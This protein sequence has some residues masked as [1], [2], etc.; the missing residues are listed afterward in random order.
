MRSE[1]TLRSLALSR[2]SGARASRNCS[3]SLLTATINGCLRLRA[4]VL[5]RFGELARAPLTPSVSVPGFPS[6]ADTPPALRASGLRQSLW[7]SPATPAVFSVRE[8]EKK[9]GP[10]PS[11]MGLTVRAEELGHQSRV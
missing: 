10:A 11:P 3:M 6:M 8:R 4:H 1:L 2:R 9:R 5:P 7:P